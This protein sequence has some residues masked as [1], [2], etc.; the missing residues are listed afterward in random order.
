LLVSND[1]FDHLMKKCFEDV[2]KN[3]TTKDVLNALKRL[4]R[5]KYFGIVEQHT[6]PAK[7]NGLFQIEEA[8]NDRL[9]IS[10]T[11]SLGVDL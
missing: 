3:G 10:Q 2:K 11:I 9:I 4:Q 5:R 6:N 7:Q 8:I 1:T